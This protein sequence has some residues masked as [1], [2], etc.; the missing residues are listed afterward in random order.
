MV[1]GEQQLFFK[2]ILSFLF[3]AKLAHQTK[4]SLTFVSHETWVG[5][6]LFR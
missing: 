5:I 2:L 4:I 3:S 1:T 6:W